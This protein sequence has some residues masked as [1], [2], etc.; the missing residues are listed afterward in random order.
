MDYWFYTSRWYFFGAQY[1]WLRCH[2]WKVLGEI[3]L[4][5][6]LTFSM[7]ALFLIWF[8]SLF[9]SN[10][11]SRLSCLAVLT[12]RLSLFWKI[13]Q[14]HQIYYQK[15]QVLEYSLML[16]EIGLSL[17]L[18]HIHLISYRENISRLNPIFKLL[19]NWIYGMSS[20]IKADPSS[21]SSSIS[22]SFLYGN[23]SK[24]SIWN[25][26]SYPSQLSNPTN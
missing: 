15:N 6:T 23:F 9:L 5:F 18:P 7:V 1:D 21:H 8:Y 16:T 2:L 26:Q 20:M 12:F 10:K 17:N 14:I 3:F 19:R 25:F 22:V 24:F 4:R 13:Q 11:R